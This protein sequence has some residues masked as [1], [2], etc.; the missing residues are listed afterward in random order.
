MFKIFLGKQPQKFLINAEN[1]LRDR[2]WKKLDELKENPFP[3][4]VKRIEGKKEK[5]FRVRV[6]N[7]RIEYIVLHQ[8]KEIV[9]FKIEKRP[10]AY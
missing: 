10:K 6:G 8:E 2:I 3:S 9:V 1:E 7:Y 4:D 5:A